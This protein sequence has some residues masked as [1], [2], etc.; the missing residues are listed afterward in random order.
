MLSYMTTTGD[1]WPYKRWMVFKLIESENWVKWRK[2]HIKL[3]L[4]LRSL[5][6]LN[7]PQSLFY[8]YF[9]RRQ[10]LFE[11]LL[12]LLTRKNRGNQSSLVNWRNKTLLVINGMTRIVL[13]MN[14]RFSSIMLD[15]SVSE[16]TNQLHSWNT[17]G[18][19]L[20]DPCWPTILVSVYGLKFIEW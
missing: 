11:I 6:S 3:T 10:L 19:A 12:R 8:H 16:S 1:N 20:P 14:V 13:E 7:S 9:P 18:N 4:P 2:G 15:I 17:L 5:C